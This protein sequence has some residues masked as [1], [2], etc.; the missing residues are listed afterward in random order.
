MLI[1]EILLFVDN[2]IM[3]IEKFETLNIN[4]TRLVACVLTVYLIRLDP[5]TRKYCHVILKTDS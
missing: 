3:Q 5:N 4:N 2:L 1:V